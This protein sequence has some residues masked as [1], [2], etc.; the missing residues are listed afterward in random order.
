MDSP[1]ELSKLQHAALACINRC[2][3]ELAESGYDVRSAIELE[4][5]AK[6]PDGSPAEIS[7]AHSNRFSQQPALQEKLQE[8]L[9]AD[10]RY[11]QQLSYEARGGLGYYA[12][13]QPVIR[14]QYEIKISGKPDDFDPAKV[15][16]V[17]RQLQSGT[18]QEALRQCGDSSIHLDFSALPDRI[19]EDSQQAAM[20]GQGV[21][22]GMHINISLYKNGINQFSQHQG[23]ENNAGWLSGLLVG[24]KTAPLV[25]QSTENHAG[26]LQSLAAWSLLQLQK[27]TWPLILRDENAKRR[28]YANNTAPGGIGAFFAAT[29]RSLDEKNNHAGKTPISARIIALYDDKAGVARLEN[30]LPCADSD[31][32]TAMALT[33]ASLVYAVRLSKGQAAPDFLQ[34]DLRDDALKQA[35]KEIRE[36]SFYSP[37]NECV[38]AIKELLGDVLCAELVSQPHECLAPEGWGQGTGAGASPSRSLP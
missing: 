28:I 21:S 4:F 3:K 9:G 25:T 26:N 29:I 11:I 2:A 24:K 38:E 8:I 14:D 20:R 7:L 34:T 13:L 12:R 1:S 37:N 30:R 33:M 32:L 22:S 18:L 5:I 6:N 19:T 15:A 10:G 23:E 35:V 27:Q 31:P 36:G 16:L 17:T